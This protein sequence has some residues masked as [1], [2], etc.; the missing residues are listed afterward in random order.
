ME[1]VNIVWASPEYPTK[2]GIFND[3][4]LERNRDQDERLSR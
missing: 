2:G 4:Q 1:T 3:T